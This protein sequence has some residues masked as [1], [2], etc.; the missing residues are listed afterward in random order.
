MKLFQVVV[1]ESMQYEYHDESIVF[2]SLDL[3]KAISYAKSIFVNNMVGRNLD[4]ISFS[5]IHS[6]I[7]YFGNLFPKSN[8]YN[9]DDKSIFVLEAE[10]DQPVDHKNVVW[11][12][13]ADEVF[14]F[15]S[16]TLDLFFQQQN[17]PSLSME[18]KAKLFNDM[19]NDKFKTTNVYDISAAELI[20]NS[21]ENIAETYLYERYEMAS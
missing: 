4:D 17:V 8:V 7:G 14:N 13:N 9:Y 6:L 10:L 18:E 15:F 20:A 11:E 3:N 5:E 16:E 2:N 12:F 1:T 21:P 19:T